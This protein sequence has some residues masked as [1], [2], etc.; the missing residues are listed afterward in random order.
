MNILDSETR[1]AGDAASCRRAGCRR[2]R[3]S[4][5]AGRRPHHRRVRHTRS[6]STWRDLPESAQRRLGA[7]R[8]ASREDDLAVAVTNRPWRPCRSS[9]AGPSSPSRNAAFAATS[10]AR[11]VAGAHGDALPAGVGRGS[12]RRDRSGGAL[13]RRPRA[14]S[15][16]RDAARCERS[17][18]QRHGAAAGS[19]TDELAAGR[20]GRRPQRRIRRP[21][22]ARGHRRLRGP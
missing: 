20:R 3:S 8:P 4:R 10:A 13:A 6:S 14:P 15:P 18:A 7:L 17:V 2:A 22:G 19:A 16:R 21:R 12:R 9:Q 11:Q 1:K 5:R